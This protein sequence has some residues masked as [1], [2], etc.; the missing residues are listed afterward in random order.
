M[1]RVPNDQNVSGYQ[2]AVPNGTHTRT[3]KNSFSKLQFRTLQARKLQFQGSLLLKGTKQVFGVPSSSWYWFG[4]VYQQATK[5][6]GGPCVSHWLNVPGRQNSSAEFQLKFFVSRSWNWHWDSQFN[7]QVEWSIGLQCFLLSEWFLRKVLQVMKLAQPV[8]LL[9][10]NNWQK[11]ASY[12]KILLLQLKKKKKS[13]VSCW[14]LSRRKQAKT[15]QKSQLFNCSWQFLSC[16]LDASSVLVVFFP[17]GSW[18]RVLN[19]HPQF[20][21][22]FCRLEHTIKLVVFLH[23][24]RWNEALVVH[25]CHSTLC[26]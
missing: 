15:C 14:S 18:F 25:R 6:T 22:F 11:L 8:L 16:H 23:C 24:K 9:P 3:R 2:C 17:L 4:D 7:L 5:N 19:W 1:G 21:L 20:K 13:A 26:S 10:T 12:E